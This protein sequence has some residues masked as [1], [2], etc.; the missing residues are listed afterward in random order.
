MS[1]P[2][3]EHGLSAEHGA[4]FADLARWIARGAALLALLAALFVALSAESLHSLYVNGPRG[5]FFGVLGMAGLTVSALAGYTAWALRGASR[6][7]ARV[8]D[9]AGRD[10]AHV[11]DAMRALRRIFWVLRAAALAVAALV[12]IAYVAH[13][14]R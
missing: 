14:G 3:T 4:L 9:T 2:R 7:V 8:A 13:H 1:A 11:M 10:V 5:A 12:V 6:S